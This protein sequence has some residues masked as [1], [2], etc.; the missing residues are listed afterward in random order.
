MQPGMRTVDRDARKR[1]SRR[2]E[3]PARCRWV[4]VKTT[5]VGAYRQ[6]RG[7]LAGQGGEP[8]YA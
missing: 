7:I 3:R 2:S 4:P 5:L 1:P 8:D 6:L